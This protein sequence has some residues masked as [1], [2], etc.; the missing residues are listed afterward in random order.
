[1]PTKRTRRGRNRRT[2]I[3]ADLVNYLKDEPGIPRDFYFWDERDIRAAWNEVKDSILADWTDTYPGTRPLHWWKF[4]APEPRRRVGGTGTPAHE[5][6]ANLPCYAFGI[7]VSWVSQWQ[8]DYYNGRRRDVNGKRIGTEYR[9]GHFAG[10]AI[11][12]EDPPLYE[13]EAEYLR[14][15]GLLLPGERKRLSPDDFESEYIAAEA[16]P[17]IEDADGTPDEAA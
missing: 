17:D 4:E 11:D 7:P 10:V 8:A 15:H 1:M 16:D 13:S 5:V 6:F 2:E 3:P 9:E 14:R 12:P